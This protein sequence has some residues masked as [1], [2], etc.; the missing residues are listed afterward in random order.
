[1]SRETELCSYGWR[2]GWLLVSSLTRIR[3]KVLIV[4]T[5]SYC[6]WNP[7]SH[8]WQAT[9][10]HRA[11][12]TITMNNSSESMLNSLPGCVAVIYQPETQLQGTLIS[13]LKGNSKT[14]TYLLLSLQRAGKVVALVG[15]STRIAFPCFSCCGRYNWFAHC[16]DWIFLKPHHIEKAPMLS[17]FAIPIITYFLVSF[18]CTML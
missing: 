10:V 6:L 8:S 13:T 18:L 5:A 17:F 7:D 12:G 15:S 14:L 4:P 11:A 1:M 16:L 2:R 3:F 9:C